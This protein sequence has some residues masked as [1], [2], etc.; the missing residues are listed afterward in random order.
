MVSLHSACVMP[1]RA[2]LA[3]LYCQ[4]TNAILQLQGHSAFSSSC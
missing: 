2:G 1:R 3:V 4:N